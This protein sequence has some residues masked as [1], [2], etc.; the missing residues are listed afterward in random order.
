MAPLAHI[1]VLEVLGLTVWV[2]VRGLADCMFY[3]Q[4]VCT[5]SCD[6][7][8]LTFALKRCLFSFDVRGR[9]LFVSALLFCNCAFGSACSFG[10]LPGGCSS[11][12]FRLGVRIPVQAAEV[13]CERG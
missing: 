1:N 13:R 7:C 4:F 6:G 11:C 2:P 9:T 12:V 8:S 3:V 10:M 5:F